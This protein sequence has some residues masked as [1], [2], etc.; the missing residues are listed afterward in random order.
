LFV[1][2]L[3]ELIE[4]KKQ[5]LQFAGVFHFIFMQNKRNSGIKVNHL[6]I[7]GGSFLSFVRNFLSKTQTC[8]IKQFILFTSDIA[9]M[10]VSFQTVKHDF[11]LKSGYDSFKE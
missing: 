4:F 11:V 9:P 5:D 1:G 3:I 2:L 8:R 10:N 6:K 7:C